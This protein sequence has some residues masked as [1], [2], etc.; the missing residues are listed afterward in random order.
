MKRLV[1]TK[2]LLGGTVVTILE[3]I[4]HHTF[5][6]TDGKFEYT[7]LRYDLKPIKKEA[8]NEPLL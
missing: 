2:W 7:V 8:Q 4:D 6:V 1:D 5:L 3:E